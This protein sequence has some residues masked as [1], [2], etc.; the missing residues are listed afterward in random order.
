[1]SREG[2]VRHPSGWDSLPGCAGPLGGRVHGVGAEARP[3]M[4]SVYQLLFVDRAHYG[5]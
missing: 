1:M 3:H 4:D 5:N 2:R